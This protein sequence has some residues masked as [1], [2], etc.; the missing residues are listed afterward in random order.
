MVMLVRGRGAFVFGSAAILTTDGDGTVK[1]V[2]VGA[3]G[4]VSA[5]GGG[6]AVGGTGVVSAGC[7]GSTA[8]AAPVAVVA[9]MAVA[10][11]SKTA[12]KSN[13]P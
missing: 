1:I 5:G 12:S 7:G 6:G 4:V 10:V 8:A 9:R 2:S 3:A 13:R 11:K